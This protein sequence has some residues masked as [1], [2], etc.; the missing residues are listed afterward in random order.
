MNDLLR[1][2]EIMKKRPTE[3]FVMATIF[4]VEGSA[5]R[6][7]GAKM[8]IDESGTT[9][10]ILSA[11]CLEEDLMHRAKEVFHT[12]QSKT[13]TYD[14]RGEDD[15][16]WGQGAGCH[17]TVHIFLEATSWKNGG[18]DKV[19]QKLLAGVS[20]ISE[21][22][23]VGAGTTMWGEDGEILY[24]MQE[25]EDS[26]RFVEQYQPRECLYV[27]GAGP[28]AEPIVE[29]ADKVDFSVCLIDPRSDRCSEKYF[30]HA[31]QRIVEFPD[32][33]LRANSIPKNSYVLIM[34]HN[35]QWDQQILRHFI[36]HK[37]P[38]HYL[39]I[40]G[41]KQRTERL[42]SPSPI[43]DWIHAPVGL[44]IGAEGPEEIAVSILAELIQC[45]NGKHSR[46]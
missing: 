36:S 13:M 29:Y 1:A 6:R 26:P 14:L 46:N 33:Y 18:W 31:E 15:L 28:D 27:F 24:F 38:P 41:S 4:R 3:R 12:N 39:G 20:V 2:L 10:G 22:S 44:K 9:H 45:R 8:L 7:E 43:P 11:G 32:L 5:Y 37:D 25:T 21:K 42:L 17:G 19:E 30:P 40:L 23:L 35:F 16:S 34:T